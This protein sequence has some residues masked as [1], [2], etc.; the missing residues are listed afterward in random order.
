[1]HCQSQY[2]DFDCTEPAFEPFTPPRNKKYIDEKFRI[3]QESDTRLRNPIYAQTLKKAGFRLPQK[4]LSENGGDSIYLKVTKDEFNV[5]IKLLDIGKNHP[6]FIEIAH[7]KG[8]TTKEL[9]LH[10]QLVRDSYLAKSIVKK[11]SNDK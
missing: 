5:A 6:A 3:W 2:I 7:R 1:M 8:L 11:N 4:Y 9:L 10:S